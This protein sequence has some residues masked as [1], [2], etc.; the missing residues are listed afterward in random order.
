MVEIAAFHTQKRQK[1]NPMDEASNNSST[2]PI[3]TE[4]MAQLLLNQRHWREA[5][6]I[7]RKLSRQNPGKAQAYEKEIS[8]I[9]EYFKP[10]PSPKMAGKTIRTQR[11]IAHLKKLLKVA[12]KQQTSICK[13]RSS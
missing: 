6:D 4:T 12:E 5:I 3:L 2:Q 9:K 10:Q 11:R 7:Y 8:Q 1:D 13:Q